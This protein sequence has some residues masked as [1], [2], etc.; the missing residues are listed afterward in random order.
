M[1]HTRLVGL[2]PYRIR[3]SSMRDS[4]IAKPKESTWHI[5]N[6][7]RYEDILHSS[8]E[9]LKQEIA[10][11]GPSPEL[12]CI[13]TKTLRTWGRACG[14][15]VFEAF[16]LNRQL[17]SELDQFRIIH[18]AE[19]SRMWYTNDRT[20]ITA[21]CESL[22]PLCTVIDEHGLHLYVHFV[23]AWINRFFDLMLD[24]RTSAGQEGPT[25][26][27]LKLEWKESGRYKRY[28]DEFE[29]LQ[30]LIIKYTE[31]CISIGSSSGW[32]YRELT[33]VFSATGKCHGR[34]KPQ[35][36]DAHAIDER[37][38]LLENMEEVY[39]DIEDLDPNPGPEIPL[40]DIPA[41]R[42]NIA[43]TLTQL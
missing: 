5:Y 28:S 23:C 30:D 4:N 32:P 37:I 12:L 34:K 7:L 16:L 24:R 19:F 3:N 2:P 36:E 43:P 33:I 11:N 27:F 41:K 1:V 31:S 13:A 15:E 9:R 35:Y 21:I 42:R 25:E 26:S 10:D 8:G 29:R 18:E 20:K 22:V 39:S 6:S 14:M 40:I 38:I 17:A